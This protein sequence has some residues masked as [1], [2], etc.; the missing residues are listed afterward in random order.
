MPISQ[1]SESDELKRRLLFVPCKS[2]KQLHDWIELYLGLDIPDCIVDP[3]SNSS[4]MHLIWEVYETGMKKGKMPFSRILA[5]AS[6]DSF[7]T[8]G[9]SILEVLSIV[10]M[11]R[12]VAHMAAIEPQAQ[13]AVQY[14]KDFL[15]RPYLREFVV[16]DNKR[17]IEI[18]RY[19]N[20]TT[21]VSITPKAWLALEAE[22]QRNQYQEIKNYLQV[23]I[24]TPR[25]ANSAHV[26]F[27]VVDE[28]D[29]AEPKAYEE[30]KMIPAPYQGRQPIT[31]LTSTRKISYGLVQKEIDK[32][33]DRRTG[34]RVLQVRHWNI[35][36]VTE[37][38][39]AER[40]RP[41]L[42]KIPIYFSNKSLQS[43]REPDY[44]LLPDDDKRGYTKKE[45]YEG[46]MSSC[47]LFAVCQ[48]RLATEQKSKSS[49]LKP[50][51]HVIQLF[52][53]VSVNTAQAQLMCWKP[54][55]EG[56]IYP[57]FDRA[58]H[59]L[60]AFEIAEKITGEAHP[61]T[62]GKAD[63]INL[64]KSRDITFHSGMDFGFT[65]NFAV[66]TAGVDGG[67]VYVLDVIAVP[68]IELMQKIELCK[69]K[70]LPFDVSIYADEA[71]PSDIKTFSKAGF[72]IRGV[73][74][75]K[76]SVVGGIEI[77]RSKLMP[78]RGKPQLYLLAGDEGCEILA[79]R[80][81]QY[82]WKQDTGGN[83]LDIP[84]EKDDDEC[85]AI[86][87]LCMSLFAPKGKF[88]NPALA[89]DEQQQSGAQQA[90]Y[91]AQNWMKKQIQEHIGESGEIDGTDPTT[92]SGKRGGFSWSFG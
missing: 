22:S 72:R 28:V 86:R 75:D 68:G 44:D 16:A 19:Y 62:F 64:M 24:C 77:V 59:M 3:D 50:I 49:L 29:L 85:D 38:C 71:Y 67:N 48:G 17:N 21:G 53:D 83:M 58:T 1:V 70:I 42:P 90:Q 32:Q 41:D 78:A 46:C 47:T 57:N 30:A 33:L 76:G 34:R 81:S 89:K 6:R 56:L 79:Q 36:D 45:G 25:G 80:M 18:R 8:L 82:H 26:P 60:R 61:E 54:S 65:H 91:T 35:M 14:V 88:M 92:P 51:D 84:N 4:P 69:Q 9:A 11:Q 5:Y 43:L 23:V 40:H 73:K 55:T 31:L 20:K 2:M 27:F 13:K 12:S 74:K 66:V 87:Y 10:H 63:L 39:P 52:S 37:P 7:K 15:N